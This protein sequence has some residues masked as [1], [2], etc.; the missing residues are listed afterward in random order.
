MNAPLVTHELG[1]PPLEGNLSAVKIVFGAV[2]PKLIRTTLNG[3][4][5]LR[6][7]AG[8]FALATVRYKGST[9]QFHLADFGDHWQLA[10]EQG[11]NH[12][13]NP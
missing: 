2:A 9:R 8:E 1:Y 3:V 12:R 13:S 6:I 4:V 7:R 11:A 10:L 5:R